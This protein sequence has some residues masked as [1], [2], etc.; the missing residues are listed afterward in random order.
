MLL[1]KVKLHQDPQLDKIEYQ[2]AYDLLEQA[3]ANTWFPH[4]VP[5]MEDLADW[6]TMS[7]E[8]REAVTLFMGFFNPAEFRVNQSIV[9]GMMP[10]LSAPEVTMYLTRQMWEEVNHSMSFEYVLQTF[11]IDRKRAFSLHEDLPSMKAKED[12]LLDHV[13]ALRG[14][15]IDISSESGIQTF[16]KNIVAT[17]IITEGIW[18]YSGF[19]LGLSFRQRNLLKNFAN[20][21]D[22]IVRD[23]SLHLKFGINL[24]LTILEEHPEIVTEEFADEVREMIIKA[25]QLESK[26]TE[27]LLPNGILGLNA[28][29]VM[30][31][32]KYIA[33][34]RLEELGFDTE[35][36][37]GNPAKWMGTANDTLELVNFFETVNT[38][39]EVNNG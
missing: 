37:V 36:N 28:D 16:V 14:G 25:V 22:W 3:V 19:M 35:F 33:D 21:V 1:Q 10:Y 13:S 2:W 9:M 32:V 18:F 5:L 31:Y 23:E 38:N 30:Q 7:D 12:F 34:R 20:L 26:Y 4:E 24:V 17:N 29:Y 15:E 8:E 6:R 11:P 39:Y 27:Q